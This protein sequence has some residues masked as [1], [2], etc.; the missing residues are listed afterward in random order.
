MD[1]YIKN[2][3]SDLVEALVGD[4]AE[5]QAIAAELGNAAARCRLLARQ[6]LPDNYAAELDRVFGSCADGDL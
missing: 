4:G 3:V 6:P 5:L 2:A 1:D